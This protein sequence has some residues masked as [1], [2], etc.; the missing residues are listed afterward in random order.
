MSYSSVGYRQGAPWRRWR[1]SG[2]PSLDESTLAVRYNVVVDEVPT[3]VIELVDLLGGTT[4][5]LV[6]DVPIDGIMQ[7]LG[8]GRFVMYGDQNRVE[9]P[10]TAAIVVDPS[11]DPPTTS[12][13]PGPFSSHRFAAS[14]L[15]ADGSVAIVG[16]TVPDESEELAGRAHYRFDPSDGTFVRRTP[17][18]FG[19]TKHVLLPTPTGELLV[20]NCGRGTDCGTAAHYVNASTTLEVWSPATDSW[21]YTV[22]DFQR[23]AP[24]V[25]P[26]ADG[27]ILILGGSGNLRT[28]DGYGGHDGPLPHGQFIEP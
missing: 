17:M 12:D 6:V 18:T 22:I 5:R 27:R 1:S 14:A 20:V 3:A 19:R 15:L 24:S 23:R 4:R 11:T 16:G 10:A 25:T 28:D 7:S 13:F 2:S 9:G 26:L 21:R 8:D